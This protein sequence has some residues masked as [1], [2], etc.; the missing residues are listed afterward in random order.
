[1]TSETIVE[2]IGDK[3]QQKQLFMPLYPREISIIIITIIVIV[4]II[5]VH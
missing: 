2:F 5:T 3:L 1:M 4:K